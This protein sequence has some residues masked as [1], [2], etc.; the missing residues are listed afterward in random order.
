MGDEPEFEEMEQIP[1]S[2]LA[3]R[4]PNPMIR[5][6]WV[7]GG[8]A[9]AII[10]MLV[11]RG[12][13]GGGEETQVTLPAASATTTSLAEP[14]GVAVAT[15]PEPDLYSEADL[16]AAAPGADETLAAMGAEWFVR[17]YF[18]VDGDEG[19]ESELLDLVGDGVLPHRAPTGASYVEWTRAFSV[20]S[21]TPGRYA[22]T[23]AYRTLTS[24]DGTAFSRSPA[25]AVTVPIAVDADGSM[26][27]LD[28]PQP[29][30]LPALLPIA[31]PRGDE[32]TPPADVSAAARQA[33]GAVGSDPVVVSAT[34]D[35]TGW[36][37][38]VAVG[39]PAG[40]RWP[41][42]VRVEP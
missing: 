20:S 27:L 37:V 25:R 40:L 28:L 41:L 30:K 1:W 2:A 36:R 31:G 14:A 12:L 42:A 15:V 33:A 17:D 13:A 29:A 26:M 34:R 18:T 22:V 10:G 24:P 4:T 23:V 5:I 11:A 35:D 21:D 38:V 9:A 6:G 32:A 16:M 7:V 19:L 8:V 39:D 3:A